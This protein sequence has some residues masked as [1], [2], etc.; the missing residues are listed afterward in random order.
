MADCEVDSFVN[1]FKFLCS[2]GYKATLTIEASEGEAFVTLKTGLGHIVPPCPIKKSYRR[3]PSYQRRQERRQAARA[4]AAAASSSQTT[5]QE[6]DVK[7][8]AEESSNVLGPVETDSGMNASEPA[9]KA[10]D[11]FS[12]EICDFRSNWAN[13]LA[14]HM[15]RKHGNIEQLDG[16]SSMCEDSEKEKD[17]KYSR[18]VHYWK[19]LRLGFGYQTF[20]DA[21]EVIES[22]DMSENEKE[23]EKE[24]VLEARK[25]ALGPSFKFFPPWD[26]K[27]SLGG[28]VPPHY[29][30]TRLQ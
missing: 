2:A 14:I 6:G 25:L 30:T 29:G 11:D 27:P 4:A 18:T 16:S 23:V 20:L 22:C 10:G 9:D 19:E 24:K 5:V 8:I 12:C 21:I 28:G 15:T 13:G 1:K 26:S 7:D 17:E 3:G